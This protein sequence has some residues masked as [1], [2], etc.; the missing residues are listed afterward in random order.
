MN[1][2][3]ILSNLLATVLGLDASLAS[4]FNDDP[5][6]LYNTAEKLGIDPSTIKNFLNQMN[7]NARMRDNNKK[8]MLPELEGHLVQMM[9]QINPT[10]EQMESFGDMLV[11]DP[12]Y[13]EQPEF[14]S[15]DA[16][17][18]VSTQFK[19]GVANLYEVNVQT[20]GYSK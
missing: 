17:L 7:Y 9:L 4:R 13:M 12:N 5:K 16:L 20:T 10:K 3:Y 1:D 19:Q 11:T 15:A 6:Y 18:Q 14:Y 8:S 2:E